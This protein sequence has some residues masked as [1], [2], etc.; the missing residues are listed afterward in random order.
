M[1]SRE[2]HDGE[3]TTTCNGYISVT[4]TALS[5]NLFVSYLIK[6]ALNDFFDRSEEYLF[7]CGIEAA[8][9]MLGSGSLIDLAFCE[10]A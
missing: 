1:W 6:L 5:T 7:P 2:E 9:V 8:S 3:S 10:R 4:T